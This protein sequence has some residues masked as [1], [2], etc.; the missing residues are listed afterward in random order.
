MP[1]ST[2]SDAVRAVL[3]LTLILNL[4]VAVGKI[5]TG[6]ATGAIAITAD[7]IHSL[8]DAASNVLALL[9]NRVAARPPDADH[10]YG[11]RR[12]ETVAALAL[13]GLLLLTAWEII[14]GVID[15]LGGGAAPDMTPAAFVV[16]IATLVVNVG[17]SRYERRKGRELGSE[18]LLAD[19]ANTG[20]DV[21]VTLS[22]LI[23]M[24]L[25][26]LGI[27]W[28][29]AAAAI[30]V[31]ILIARTGIEVMR[32]ASG[33]LVDTAPYTP[34][35]LT[36][37]AHTVPAVGTVM[38]ARSR[39]SSHAATI[40]IDLQVDPAM[41]ADH[42]G[43]IARAVE[44]A[45]RAALPGVQEVEVHFASAPPSD[46]NIALIVRAHADALGLATHEV[47]VI[48]GE[49]GRALEMHVEVPSGQTL[50]AAHDRVT[51]LEDKVRAALPD[52]DAIVSHIEPIQ[53][54]GRNGLIASAC[55]PL[56]E[57][58]RTL[59]ARR[60]PSFNWH[61]FEVTPLDGG[62]RLTVHV[63]L[64]GSLTLERAHQVAEGA[65]LLLRTELPR[66]AR[67]T[68]HTEPVE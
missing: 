12:F 68:I 51:Q 47:Q 59:L 67:V 28:A 54:G 24:A 19:A 55:E 31:V 16:L 62:C 13:G 1:D 66:L 4:I 30:I 10:P 39:G 56:L 2:R 42:T 17:V 41:T 25:V 60:Y 18:L 8:I 45:M 5:A 52:V 64:P 37:I 27:G 23:S 61:D 63:S 21:W 3:R 53:T 9:A 33:V 50:Q 40:D 15:R 43:A 22:V 20:A 65:E 46:S 14:S 29:D 6:A 44:E 32:H 36:A 38:R 58:A 49:S 57:Q 11:H 7:G 35:R 48:T 34:E 26:A